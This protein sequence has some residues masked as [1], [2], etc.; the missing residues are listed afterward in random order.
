MPKRLYQQPSPICTQNIA[1]VQGLLQYS[2]IQYTPQSYT[3]TYCLGIPNTQLY[4]P[5]PCTHPN[6]SWNPA[7]RNQHYLVMSACTYNDL[8]QAPLT[9]QTPIQGTIAYNQVVNNFIQVQLHTINWHVANLI[10]G[11]TV[12]YYISTGFTCIYTTQ[13]HACCHWIWLIHRLS[14]SQAVISVLYSDSWTV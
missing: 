3:C 14:V 9:S 2:T 7:Q 1:T 8:A 6:P 11:I 13:P 10:Q 4:T 5:D 12:P